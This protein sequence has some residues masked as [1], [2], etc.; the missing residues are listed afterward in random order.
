M[1][2]GLSRDDKGGFYAEVGNPAGKFEGMVHKA[3]LLAAYSI[4]WKASM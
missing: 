2:C 1:R 3:M 4:V